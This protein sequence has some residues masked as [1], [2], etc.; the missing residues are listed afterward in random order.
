MGKNMTSKTHVI[1][2]KVTCT[3]WFVCRFLLP[4]VLV[5]GLT[6]PNAEPIGRGK[7]SINYDCFY[8]K[9]HSNGGLIIG[10]VHSR[11]PTALMQ[12]QN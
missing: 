1:R 6:G 4:Q 2:S 8:I 9:K 11:G 5:H 3:K 10:G 12:R 7:A